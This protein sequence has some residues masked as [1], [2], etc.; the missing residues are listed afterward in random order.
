MC[1]YIEICSILKLASVEW[2]ESSKSIILI[3]VVKIFSCET[4]TS[5][6]CMQAHIFILYV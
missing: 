2:S 3:T 1:L 5:F 4:G 6:Y